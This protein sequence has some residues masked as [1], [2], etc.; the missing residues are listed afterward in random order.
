MKYTHIIWDFNGTLLNDVKIGIETVNHLLEKRRLK[1][2][3]SAEEYRKVFCFPVKEYYRKLGFDFESESYEVLAVEWVEQYLIREKDISLYPG[4]VEVLE[5][6]ND[7]GLE[8][9]ILSATE[10]AML[11]KQLR[12]LNIDCY[13]SEILGLDNIYAHSKAEMAKEWAMNRKNLRALMVGDTVHDCEVA[14][15]AGFDCILISHGHHSSDRLRL[16]GVPA[17][18]SLDE[19]L[20]YLN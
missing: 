6:I 1:T 2:L 17:I 18:S 15:Y 9:V 19:I 8:Q 20:N 3:Q 7:A 14:Q 11:N 16:C 5:K 4:A 12:A 10:S 13:F